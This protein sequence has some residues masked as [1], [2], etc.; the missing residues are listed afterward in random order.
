M[1]VVHFKK[2]NSEVIGTNIQVFFFR[3]EL[4]VPAI[5]LPSFF[6]LLVNDGRKYL[7]CR[8]FETCL[9]NMVLNKKP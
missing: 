4:F 5:A 7:F 9:S 1:S 8:L 3:T 6:F 2:F